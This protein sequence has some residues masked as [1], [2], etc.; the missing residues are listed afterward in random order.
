MSQVIEKIDYFLDKLEE[1]LIS[2]SL[3]IIISVLFANVIGRYFFLHSIAW[4]EELSRYLNIWA[5]FIGVSAGVKK[6]VHIGIPAFVNLVIPEREKKAAVILAEIIALSFCVFIA[7]YGYKLSVAQFEMKQYSPALELPIGLA[8]SAI[9]VG[10]LLS[11]IRYL[12]K[13]FYQLTG[14]GREER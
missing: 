8:Y 6:G 4:A 9:P 13:I 11:S 5:V 2:I 14:E 12:Q 10:M 3:L 7:Y 1:Y